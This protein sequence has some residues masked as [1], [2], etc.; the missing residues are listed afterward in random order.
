M[1]RLWR[2]STVRW[3]S[4]RWWV[5][6]RPAINLLGSPTFRPDPLPT[7]LGCPPILEFGFKVTPNLGVALRTVLQ[8]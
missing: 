5:A 3:P 2:P 7:V 1:V 4:E 6:A 8:W